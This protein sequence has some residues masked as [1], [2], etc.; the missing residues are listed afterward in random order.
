MTEIDKTKKITENDRLTD[1]KKNRHGMPNFF[2]LTVLLIVLLLLAGMLFILLYEPDA[3]LREEKSVIYSVEIK[4]AAEGL[5]RRFT[6][7]ETLY[8][9][10]TGAVIGEVISVR[11]V[12]SAAIL[13]DKTAGVYVKTAYPG[14]EDI[15]V[16]VRAAA[17]VTETAYLL[18]GCRIAVGAP[19][20]LH[21]AYLSAEGVCTSLYE[22]E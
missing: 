9:T 22:E 13:E 19:V 15:Y 5:S 18:E 10:E 2:D 21:T 4:N 6:V 8:D 14:Y 11:A 1:S 16:T 3:P 20:R 7:G 17:S 12:P